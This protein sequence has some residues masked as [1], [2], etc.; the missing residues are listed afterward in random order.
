M[1]C[2][3]ADAL[4]VVKNHGARRHCFDMVLDGSQSQGKIQLIAGAVAQPLD[5]DV[6]SVLS[7]RN[8]DRL[9]IVSKTGSEARMVAECKT[10]EEL[11]CPTQ[12]RPLMFLTEG[13]DGSS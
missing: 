8:Q 12:H 1:T 2:S 9:V 4:D 11:T 6:F 3:A 10:R 7:D 13:F 5:F